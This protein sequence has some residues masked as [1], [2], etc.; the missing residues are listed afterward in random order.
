MARC[1]LPASL[2]RAGFL[3]GSPRLCV[4]HIWPWLA[5]ASTRTVCA[6][7]RFPASYVTDRL[8]DARRG[9]SDLLKVVLR[10]AAV[11]ILLAIAAAVV[12]G[13]AALQAIGPHLPGARWF[14]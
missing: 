3:L 13:R 11:P 4:A 1:V 7:C 9:Y 6:R 8:W 10:F 14:T 5:R 2:P 12:A